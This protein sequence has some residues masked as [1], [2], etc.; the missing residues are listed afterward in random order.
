ME[1]ESEE[2]QTTVAK[3]FFSVRE[4]STRGTGY[5]RMSWRLPP[6][7]RSRKDWMT[8]AWMWNHNFISKR[9]NPLSL[10][11]T[12]YL[13]IFAIFTVSRSMPFYTEPVNFRL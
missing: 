3:V 7:I 9:L 5:R 8:E 4:S 10:Q 1:V 13:H 6:S 11:V 12:S 2:K